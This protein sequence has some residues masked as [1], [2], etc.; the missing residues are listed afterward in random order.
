MKYFS[1]PTDG[2]LIYWAPC[3]EEQTPSKYPFDGL[4]YKSDYQHP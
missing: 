3:I 2:K 1:L 4:N